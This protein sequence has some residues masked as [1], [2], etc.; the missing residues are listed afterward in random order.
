MFKPILEKLVD[1]KW[2]TVIQIDD[3]L[4][5]HR[6]LISEAKQFHHE[7]FVV[8]R[9]GRDRL[10]SFFE[11]NVFLHNRTNFVERDQLLTGYSWLHQVLKKMF[12]KA[13]LYTHKVYQKIFSK[14]FV[15]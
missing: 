7:K 3:I 14:Q 1:A 8:F 12:S 5:Q 11:S 4:D 10:D 2:R 6:R 9:F 15:I 13:S